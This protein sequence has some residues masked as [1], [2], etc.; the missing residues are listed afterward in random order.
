[1]RAG[2]NSCL[3]T[4]FGIDELLGRLPDE[5]SSLVNITLFSR[6]PD[7]REAAVEVVRVIELRADHHSAVAVYVTVLAASLDER[8]T[9]AKAACP[10][11][12][13]RDH[14]KRGAVDVAEL[15]IDDDRRESVLKRAD[16]SGLRLNE[17]LAF[18][19]DARI[20][21]TER[22]ARQTFREV[23]CVVVL[24]RDNETACAVNVAV[25]VINDDRREALEKTRG[26]VKLRLDDHPPAL[27][28]EAILAFDHDERKSLCKAARRVV[29][30]VDDEFARAVYEAEARRLAARLHGRESFREETREVNLLQI[31]NHLPAF[32]DHAALRARLYVSQ[33]FGELPRHIILWFDDDLTRAINVA[34]LAVLPDGKQRGRVTAALTF[35]RAAIDAED[36]EED[37]TKNKNCDTLRRLQS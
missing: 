33:P 9:F 16:V 25:L 28:Y 18:A 22:D 26:L 3:L 32:V 11:E 2:D 6:E 19:I 29:L 21:S 34:P 31:D 5:V 13:R 20:S 8:E 23:V 35:L 1:M 30:R 7:T 14:G 4:A 17:H 12:L 27:V 10:V 24:R 15:V 36:I 37:E